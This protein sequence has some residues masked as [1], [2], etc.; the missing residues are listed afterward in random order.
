MVTWLANKGE[1]SL[2][3]LH[4]TK[5][6]LVT[7]AYS[8]YACNGKWNFPVVWTDPLEH[9]MR[10]QKLT[11][12]EFSNSLGTIEWRWLVWNR[13]STKACHQFLQ[14]GGI[15]LYISKIV[16]TI[17]IPQKVKFF[18]FLGYLGKIQTKAN[19]VKYGWQGSTNCALCDS[20]LET[21]DHLFLPT[22]WIYKKGMVEIP[23]W[24]PSQGV[25][26]VTNSAMEWMEIRQTHTLAR[27]GIGHLISSWNLVYM[28]RTEQEVLRIPCL[29]CRCNDTTSWQAIHPSYRSSQWN[30]FRTNPTNQDLCKKD[31]RFIR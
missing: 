6:A 9:Q 11:T 13:S 10:S 2:A 31:V 23:S 8:L 28:K 15:C 14:D 18:L 5:E 27:Q 29:P 7:E 24:A 26:T 16:W 4:S 19:L 17:N 25:L 3:I 21:A 12:V 20:A 22:V 30:R 1:V